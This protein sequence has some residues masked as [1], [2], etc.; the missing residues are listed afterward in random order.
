MGVLVATI[1][2]GIGAGA[3]FLAG[4][5]IQSRLRTEFPWGTAV[6]NA[7]GA[8]LLG[9]V[10]GTGADGVEAD[11]AAGL[12]AGFTTYSTWMIETVH[13]WVEGGDGR[14]RAGVNLVGNLVVALAAAG[15]GMWLGP[16]FT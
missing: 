8:L 9:L 1:A 3:R 4:S 15:A 16:R 11:A 6:V 14:R 2:G 13:L 7:V 12:L 5:S 10:V